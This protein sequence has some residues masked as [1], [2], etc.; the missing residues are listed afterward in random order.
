MYM[1]RICSAVL[2]KVFELSPDGRFVIIDEGEFF[3]AFPD[4]S[5][6]TYDELE[7]ALTLLK[8][9][10]YIDLKYSRGKMFCVAP[11]KRY[12]EATPASPP[13]NKK[14]ERKT[15]FVFISAFA[16]SALGSL[17]ISLIFALV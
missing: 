12:I 9:G 17:I 14:Q 15:D 7:R 8:S 4:E 16:G 3:D 2:G 13:Q 1:D 10:G 6:K 11:L 5:E